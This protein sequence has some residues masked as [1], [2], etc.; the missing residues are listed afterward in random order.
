MGWDGTRTKGAEYK[1]AVCGG[2]ANMPRQALV[3]RHPTTIAGRPRL[4]SAGKDGAMGLLG[5][6]VSAALCGGVLLREPSGSGNKRQS[7]EESC[8]TCTQ[9]SS[10]S[11]WFLCGGRFSTRTCPQQSFS[12]QLQQTPSKQTARCTTERGRLLGRSPWWAYCAYLARINRV[13]V[14][15]AAAEV[16]LTLC[17]PSFGCSCGLGSVCDSSLL[18]VSHDTPSKFLSHEDQAE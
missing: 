7:C 13:W 15:A 5:N 16:L 3:S 4:M 17:P 2:A 11:L 18:L 14:A 12:K 8:C 1:S 10:S 6:R 9:P